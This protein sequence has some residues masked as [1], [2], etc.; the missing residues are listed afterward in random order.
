[1]PPGRQCLRVPLAANDHTCPVSPTGC[2]PNA[3]CTSSCRFCCILLLHVLLLHL[4]L[5]AQCAAPHPRAPWP[6]LSLPGR[7]GCWPAQHHCLL[8]P[9]HPA[10][11]FQALTHPARLPCLLMAALQQ[12]GVQRRRRSLDQQ[13]SPLRVGCFSNC[14][15]DNANGSS[16]FQ[17]NRVQI[18]RLFGVFKKGQGR[19]GPTSISDKFKCTLGA[20]T[21]TID[22]TV[23][24]VQQAN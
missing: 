8:L 12:E 4:P 20:S 9:A 1:M 15:P 3:C 2:K 10:A 22:T 6:F 23:L 18:G 5:H 16:A 7:T 14:Q 19:K 11:A 24:R 21:G 17:A 13:S